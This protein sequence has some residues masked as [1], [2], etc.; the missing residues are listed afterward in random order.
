MTTNERET[1]HSEPESRHESE[2]A[3]VN[4]TLPPI[5]LPG[6]V[7]ADRFEIRR[8]LGQ[9]GMGQVFESFDRE[10]R[11]SVAVKVLRPDKGKRDDLIDRFRA[12]VELARRVTHPH[13]C[14][15]FDL[16]PLQPSSDTWGDSGEALLLLTMELVDGETLAARVHR[17]GSLPLA[18]VETLTRQMA[19]AL[20]AAHGAGVTHRDFK[21]S[22]IVLRGS[23]EDSL[24]AVVTD[25]GLARSTGSSSHS[26]GFEGTPAYAAPEVRAGNEATVRSD[27]YS[28]GA[29]VHELLTAKLPSRSGQPDLYLL[30]CPPAV[31]K[32]IERCLAS[33]PTDR[34]GSATEAADQ[35]F[36]RPKESARSRWWLRTVAAML[37]TLL[38]M[39]GGKQLLVSKTSP[40]EASQAPMALHPS[41]AMI[42]LAEAS[43]VPEF[44]QVPEDLGGERREETPW[45]GRALSEMIRFELA[46]TGQIR[47]VEG[48]RVSEVIRSLGLEA[49]TPPN[50]VDM[51]HIRSLTSASNVAFGTVTTHGDTVSLELVLAHSSGPINT[52]QAPTERFELQG[53]LS[54]LRQLARECVR[55]IMQALGEDP[56]FLAELSPGPNNSLEGSR[57][58]GLAISAMEHGNSV[59]AATL[60]EQLVAV[61]GESP[62]SLIAH[63]ELSRRQG[64]LAAAKE[65]S[66]RLVGLEGHSESWRRELQAKALED[67]HRWNRASEIYRE[68]RKGSG[69]DLGYGLRRVST[70]V[71]AGELATAS[72][73]IED[74]R[75]QLHH[76]R[77]LLPTLDLAEASV[78]EAASDYQTQLDAATAAYETALQ[79]DADSL[80][81]R[82]QLLVGSALYRL[83]RVEEAIAV[84][85]E[86]L[87]ALEAVG[88]L[89]GRA[90]AF[91]HLD[92]GFLEE[93]DLLTTAEA[94]EILRKV[95]DREGE[96]RL[97]AADGRY[98][99]HGNQSPEQLEGQLQRALTLAREIG[100][101]RAE[102]EA[103]NALALIRLYPGDLGEAIKF[104]R[105]ALR[106]AQTSG[107]QRMVAGYSMN[108]ALFLQHYGDNPEIPQK[109]EEAV[110]ILRRIG[111]RHDL[112]LALANLARNHR[113][114][115]RHE[116]A[117]RYSRE[118][119]QVARDLGDLRLTHNYLE[120]LT[121]VLLPQKK[122]AEARTASLEALEMASTSNQRDWDSLRL[123]RIDWKAGEP[124]LAEPPILEIATRNPL[125]TGDDQVLAVSSRVDLA[126][127][128]EQL[129]R[130]Q[131]AANTLEGIL[132]PTLQT[133]SRNRRRSVVRQAARL[134]Q[135]LEGSP[136]FRSTLDDAL[137]EALESKTYDDV[138]TYSIENVRFLRDID[139]A[140]E[141]C[142]VVRRGLDSTLG[143]VSENLRSQLESV[144]EGCFESDE[145]QKPLDGSA[146]TLG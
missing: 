85:R 70:L 48:P 45:I 1:T 49:G 32:G 25:F 75:L 56:L 66:S 29:V 33:N 24:E 90:R 64:D 46:S 128:Q 41:I 145:V 146:N 65:F 6:E 137:T 44:P 7:L 84:T 12:E 22:N 86:A 93:N 31:R 91:M 138:V 35:M 98:Q 107:D 36:P 140:T 3:P 118:A 104:G 15:V 18:N 103:L 116:P 99:L 4:D 62:L 135:L 108:I 27:V 16:F 133:G 143:K 110:M 117:E 57:L 61:D 63:S 9:G 79:W 109:L 34:F 14:R 42:D 21:S 5:F 83:G 142:G 141:A 26:P 13:V 38:L 58:F 130:Y 68:L 92:V 19:A 51:T 123:A 119:L 136:S 76:P 72:A 52:E 89:G 96:A 77:G 40:T 101:F 106:A 2:T 10:L 113:N 11:T 94:L 124:T 121:L 105:D 100:S 67:S 8:F 47:A 122:Y 23:H 120:L 43:E 73:L 37:A 54:E 126:R 95:G 112:S 69:G 55:K 129:E 78:A 139:L 20:D 53:E 82:A 59:E 28:F 60:L 134:H 97:L 144:A 74:L 115:G 50:P 88:N 131:D 114:N 127:I 132:P 39:W 111:A 87:I 81:A 80:A 17:L 30:D 125:D 71:R 102:A